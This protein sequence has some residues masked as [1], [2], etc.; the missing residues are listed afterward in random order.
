MHICHSHSGQIV[1]VQRYGTGTGVEEPSA[2]TQ[3][4]VAAPTKAFFQVPQS[5]ACRSR[6]SVSDDACHA[7]ADLAA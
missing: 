6:G 2:H 7:G 4:L 1:P 3:E 5:G